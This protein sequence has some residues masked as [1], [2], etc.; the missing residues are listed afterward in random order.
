MYICVFTVVAMVPSLE[1][2]DI[3][4]MTATTADQ[5]V[6]D[7]PPPLEPAPPTLTVEPVSANMCT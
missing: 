4:L 5:F 2:G 7:E 6:R 3:L 1:T